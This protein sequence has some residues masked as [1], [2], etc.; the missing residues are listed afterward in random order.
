LVIAVTPRRRAA[1]HPAPRHARLNTSWSGSTMADRAPHPRCATAGIPAL[2]GSPHPDRCPHPRLASWLVSHGWLASTV[3]IGQRPDPAGA[4]PD[5]ER[6]DIGL[7]SHRTASRARGIDDH[8]PA[9][10]GHLDGQIMA[11]LRTQATA[12][13]LDHELPR[14]RSYYI[15]VVS[16]AH[17]ATLG[18]PTPLF[19][20]PQDGAGPPDFILQTMACAVP[21]SYISADLAFRGARDR[22]HHRP[23]QHRLLLVAV[24]IRGSAPQFSLARSRSS[25]PA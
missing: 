7:N 1:A 15:T 20:G 9:P 10:A 6:V 3:S 4:L 14:F 5:L 11:S 25:R 13:G 16:H 17:V 2:A 21:N 24:V 23:Q 12:A 8:L 18:P 19:I 22:P